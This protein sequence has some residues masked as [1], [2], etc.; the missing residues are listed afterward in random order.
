MHQTGNVE[1]P[2][3][4][5][6][7]PPPLAD[8][9]SDA[10]P[11]REPDR[12]AAD[13]FAPRRTSLFR[14]L[15]HKVRR[16]GP[17]GR[18]TKTMLPL[19]IRVFAGFSKVDG[20]LME[21]DIDS[22]LGF[23]R[24]DYPEAVYSELKQLY[25]DALREQQDL[26]Q[27][28]QEL[29]GRLSLEEKILLG[30]QL[31]VL[32]SRADLQKDQ[33][34]TIYHFMTNLGIS[35]EAIDIVYQLN[36]S[37]LDAIEASPE[38]KQ[39]L[40]NLVI[41]GHEP[42]DVVFEPLTEGFSIAAFRFQNLLL[43]KNIGRNTVIARGRQL[44]P[45]EFCRI[46]EGQGILLG[47]TVLDFQDLVFY[48]NAKKDVSAT[49]LYLSLN[50]GGS[51][52]IQKSESKQSFLELK[53][54]LDTRVRALK[55][56]DARINGQKIM[57]GHSLHVSLK[58]KIVFPDRSEISIS[59]LRRRARE[60][61]GSFDL[62]PSKSEYLVSN[63]PNLL[64]KGDILLSPGAA[65]EILLRIRC[66]Y[67]Q[68]I[69]ELEVLSAEHPIYLGKTAVRGK[70][71]LKDGATITIGNSQY[72]HCDFTERIIE[73][74][75]NLFR[76]IDIDDLGHHYSDR[77]TALESVTLSAKRGE[78]ICVMG[79]SGCGKTTLLRTLAGQLKPSR[80]DIRLND[81]SLYDHLPILTPYIAYIPHENAFDPLLTVEENI[82]FASALRA[83]HFAAAER[84]R[85]ADAKL[86]ELGLNE[87]RHR[88]AGDP[89]NKNLSS[90]ERKRLNIGMDMI[91]IADVYLF[92]EPTTGLSSKDSEHVI[93]IIRGLSHNKITFVSIHQPSAKLFQMFHKA[94]L[95]DHGGRMAFFGTPEEMLDYFEDAWQEETSSP[96]PSD[97]A[98][99]L[100]ARQPD[101]IF[102]VLETPLRDFNGDIIYE[103]DRRGHLVPA[104]RFSPNYWRDR[105]A[106]HRLIEEVSAKE[107]EQEPRDEPSPSKTDTPQAPNRRPKDEWTQFLV[108]LKRS[109]LSKLRNRG[110]IATTLLEAPALAI[111]VATVLRYS[112]EGA[113]NFAS[114]FHIPTY[115]F[116]TLV[117]GMF[118]GLTNS[119]DEIIRDRVLLLRER[120]HRIRIGYYVV[121]KFI[122]LAVFA[123]IQSVIYLLIG[124]AI[125]GIRDMFLV[126][127]SW[128]F[129]TTILGV[130]AGLLISSLVSSSKT[131]LNVIPL[132][133][134]PQIILGGALIKYEE[135]NQDIDVVYYLRKWLA[136]EDEAEKAARSSDLKVPAICQFM[137]LRWSYEAIIIEHAQNNPLSAFQNDAKEQM[138]RLIAK[139]MLHPDQEDYLDQLKDARA[140][141]FGL[142]GKSP[143]DVHQTI[144]SIRNA[145]KTR[146]FKAADFEPDENGRQFSAENLY[147]N[148]KVLDLV[149]VAEAERLDYRHE[150]E[151]HKAP[152]VFF[153]IEKSLR[154]RFPEALQ[155]TLQSWL[156]TDKAYADVKLDTL[157]LNFLIM[158]AFM[159][160]GLYAL[161]LTLR[162]QLTRV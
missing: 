117:I 70:A 128:M 158:A 153:G 48:L 53:F 97:A 110:N 112:E 123:L 84:K 50:A 101:F 20:R 22:T 6:E 162:R 116:L 75:R 127:L 137:P 98:L 42:A 85:R 65:G 71:T 45:G 49:Q 14:R 76:K 99:S 62:L 31:Y 57:R 38:T 151:Q 132:V 141:T 145:L 143:R 73:E 120:N 33:L 92:D 135:M 1:D 159:I 27:M 109:F 105:F 7:P 69:G 79:P 122:T 146:T 150:K 8:L 72:L 80:G 138:D 107:I 157:R 24:Y 43:I 136:P 77:D 5:K 40:E 126:N 155:P 37:E 78:T 13:L 125:L 114:A 118:L 152:N 106:A 147:L 15:R 36:T 124:N 18:P 55:N 74:Q 86:V 134:I 144:K 54:G 19:L 93:E 68:K 25:Q 58:D 121:T 90:G 156:D 82:D 2:K 142:E 91:G 26:N 35:P 83:P 34:I 161:T 140:F 129:L 4:P 149:N 111:L 87:R 102:D 95:L 46:Y 160:V 29:A 96:N 51:L 59:D 52:F 113:Y 89:V 108:L 67:S 60:L 81:L 61:G 66:D 41:A 148:Q 88:L 23:L 64:R 32:I 44:A 9:T 21:K 94:L 47:E 115:L 39:P 3:D 30:V 154:F 100:N 17:G 130:V 119:A 56:T 10:R 12:F 139:P 104:R 11:Q 63:D 16:S 28:A 133:L 103:E 131:A